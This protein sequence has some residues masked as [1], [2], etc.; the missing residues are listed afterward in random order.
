[1][2]AQCWVRLSTACDHQQYREH[3]SNVELMLVQRHG[4]WTNINTTLNLI[5]VIQQYRD[6]YPTLA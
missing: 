4:R 6:N 1:M 3:L 2:L 5:S